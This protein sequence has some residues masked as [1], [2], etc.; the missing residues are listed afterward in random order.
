MKG[1]MFHLMLLQTSLKYSS[2]VYSINTKVRYLYCKG[3]QKIFHSKM[4]F[5]LDTIRSLGAILKLLFLLILRIVTFIM[6]KWVEVSLRFLFSKI[7]LS[8]V[9]LLQVMQSIAT[10]AVCTLNGRHDLLMEASHSG[11]VWMVANDE[12]VDK[13]EIFTLENQ[14]KN[15]YCLASKVNLP[16][17]LA[18]KVLNNISNGLVLSQ[19]S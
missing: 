8:F 7:V 14:L 1:E 3:R 18:Q 4:F 11:R 2:K 15:P 5:P 16:F 12:N 9:K 19:S 13:I 6:E 10:W 17:K